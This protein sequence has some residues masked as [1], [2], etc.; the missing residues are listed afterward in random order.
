MK[1][2]KGANYRH[3]IQISYCLV[4]DGNE[5]WL[6]MVPEFS[7]GDDEN[8]LKLNC[9]DSCAVLQINFKKITELTHLKTRAFNVT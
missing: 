9:G 2:P 1:C 7:F 6:Q 4:R 8:I 5:K 3:K